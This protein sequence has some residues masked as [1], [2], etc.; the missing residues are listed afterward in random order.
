[1]LAPADE[2]TRRAQERHDRMGIVPML[3]APEERWIKREALAAA[4]DQRRPGHW[5]G[6][7]AGI[8]SKLQGRRRPLTDVAA[9][10]EAEFRRSPPPKACSVIERFAAVL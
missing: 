6:F 3:G 9:Q 4:S 5:G 8:V 1:M 2:L 10:R 7:V